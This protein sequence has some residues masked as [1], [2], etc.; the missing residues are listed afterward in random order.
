[1]CALCGAHRL[2]ISVPSKAAA[3]QALLWSGCCS[4][5]FGPGAPAC[6]HVSVVFAGSMPAGRPRL[7]PR[8]SVILKSYN[9]H[10]IE[11]VSARAGLDARAANIVM[12]VVRAIAD[13]GRTI[14]CTI[15]QPAIDIFEARAPRPAHPPGQ[16]LR[17]RTPH[18]APSR[19]P[20][21]LRARSRLCSVL[22]PM[23]THRSH[24]T[25]Y[26]A[27]ASALGSCWVLSSSHLGK[28]P[29]RPRRPSTRCC[30]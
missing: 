7:S 28:R 24:V 1:M 27:Y 23:P 9:P 8:V 21:A 26:I 22:S 13:T 4:A 18:A 17:A 5:I 2:V 16:P 30:C 20:T 19:M 3:S 25:I 11:P 10:C 12:R 15:H 29:F 14:V 6:L